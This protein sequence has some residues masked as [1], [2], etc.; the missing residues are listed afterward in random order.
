MTFALS[1]Q[2]IQNEKK[3]PSRLTVTSGSLV[4]NLT[5][6]VRNSFCGKVIKKS[7]SARS[8]ELLEFV[9]YI[10]CFGSSLFSSTKTPQAM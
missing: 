9:L 4:P 3:S 5:P 2:M 1:I 8:D 6:P 10:T 7:S